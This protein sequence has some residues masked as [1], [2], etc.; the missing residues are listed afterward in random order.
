MKVE[1]DKSVG[2]IVGHVEVKEDS[3][4]DTLNSSSTWLF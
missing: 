4:W 2:H 1:K 3:V